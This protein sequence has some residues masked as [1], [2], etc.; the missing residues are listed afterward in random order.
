MT[1]KKIKLVVH[2]VTKNICWVH[3]SWQ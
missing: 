2:V 3:K 1:Y